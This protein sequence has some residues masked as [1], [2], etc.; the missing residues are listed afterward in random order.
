MDL[1]GRAVDLKGD[2]WLYT[3]TMDGMD[4]NEKIINIK[5][6]ITKKIIF[7]KRPCPNMERS[8]V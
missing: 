3:T 8:E 4:F 7:D 5:G 2:D 6:V 1:I